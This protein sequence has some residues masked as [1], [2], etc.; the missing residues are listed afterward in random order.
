[1]TAGVPRPIA[2]RRAISAPHLVVGAGLLMV[3]AQVTFRAWVLYPSWFYL[4]D[5]NLLRDATASRLSTDYLMEPYNGHLMPGGRFLADFVAG[6]GQLNWSLA[7]TLVVILQAL[8]SVSCLWMLTTLFGSRRGILFLLALYLTC[9]VTI[10]AMMWWAAAVN[11]LPLQIAFFLASGA[12]VRYL[13]GRRLRWLA[14]TI[15]ALAL[16]LAFWEKSVLILP[17]LALL[18]PVYFASGSLLSR[19]GGV[20][21]RYWPAWLAGATLGATYSWF[22]LAQVEQPIGQTSLSQV[23]SLAQTM[24]G[25]GFASGVVGGP[26]TWAEAPRPAAYAAPPPWAQHLAWVVIVMVVLYGCLRRVRTLRAWVLLS[27]YLAVLVIL[28][29]GGRID[30][31]GPTIG[32]EYRYLTDA[33]PIVVLCL[34][35]AYLPLDGAVDSSRPRVTPLLVQPISPVAALALMVM[36]TGSGVV[37]SWQYAHIWQTSNASEQY[38][39]TLS[40]DARAYGAIDVADTVVPDEVMSSLNAP[41][42]TVRL[43]APLV[44]GA[45]S[46]PTTSATL[47]VVGADGGIRRAAIQPG[48]TSQPGPRPDCGWLVR[49]TGRTIPLN[50][51]AFPWTWW[52]RIGYLAASD[53]SIS[54]TAGDVTIETTIN[55]GLH[56]LFVKVDGSFDEIRLSGLEPGATMCVDRI[57]VGQ[58]VPGGALP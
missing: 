56:E 49:A 27:G 41:R 19:L 37:S 12:W 35:L 25:A 13:R 54:V 38:L 34:G 52:V 20:G 15:L 22:Y 10:P 8:A 44:T 45:M 47:A 55:A 7:A 57:E 40:Q 17:V 33:V 26:W 31:F 28:L 16:G 24:I 46:F 23:G 30:A 32:L 36:V 9:A 43:F 21:R 29:A 48:V 5:Y 39:R 42:N 3:I 11:Q 1:M 50:G 18:A 58:P 14:A 2:T 4:D 6:S 53:S 51:E